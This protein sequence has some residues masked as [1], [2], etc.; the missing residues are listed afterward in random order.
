MNGMEYLWEFV[1][2]NLRGW[3]LSHLPGSI[4][5]GSRSLSFRPK[6]DLR[7]LLMCSSSYMSSTATTS[8]FS[9]TMVCL[10]NDEDKDVNHQEKHHKHI[11]N[12]EKIASKSKTAHPSTV[13]KL[14]Q[15]GGQ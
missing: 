8:S 2:P 1:D 13:V 7:F 3:Q 4:S 14:A 12:N 15:H 11:G 9:C 6:K 10:I 5:S